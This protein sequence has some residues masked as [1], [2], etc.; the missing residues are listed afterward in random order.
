MEDAGRPRG[1]DAESAVQNIL[2]DPHAHEVFDSSKIPGEIMDLAI[3][4]TR[5]L[6][7]NPNFA[8]ALVGIWYETLHVMQTDPKAR[9]EMGEASGTD[10]AGFERQLATTR[11]F[12][13]PADAIGFTTGNLPTIMRHVRDL[14]SEH[15]LMGWGLGSPAAVD[16]E[17]P[18]HSVLG[19]RAQVKLRFDDT[20][21]QDAAAGR[22]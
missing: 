16:V 13:T 3:V 2:A 8:R 14:L 21:M 17:F 11:L 9:A 15:H 4:N 7:D 19:A 10:Q 22:L 12:T 18:D 1:D 5:T 20:Y 6:H